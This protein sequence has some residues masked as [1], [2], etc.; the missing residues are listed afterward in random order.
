M[1]KFRRN[2]LIGYGVSLVLLTISSVASYISIRSLLDSTRL[3]NQTNNVMRKLDAVLSATKDG[4]S[5]QRG[6]LISND[7]DFLEPYRGARE[8]AV[9]H[10]EELMTLVREEPE[11]RRDVALLKDLVQQRF[12]V[13]QKVID[14]K[15]A[16]GQVNPVLL[17]EGRVLMERLKSLAGEIGAREETMLARRTESQNRFAAATPILIVVAAVLGLIITI[18]SFIR[19]SSDFTKRDTLQKELEQKDKEI[20]Q[21]IAIIQDIAEK[22]AAGDYKTRI[23]DEGKDTLGNLA[24]SLNRMAEALD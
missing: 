9:G 12:S 14:G 16:T 6:Y 23:T 3:V 10:T 17:E 8:R 2:L 15:N 1:S 19:V 4:E 18:I 7:P 13:L 20:S 11:Q 21:R 24:Y 5:G 22:V